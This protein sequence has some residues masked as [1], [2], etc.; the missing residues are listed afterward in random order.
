M[1]NRGKPRLFIQYFYI[2]I[3]LCHVLYILIHQ[4]EN[5][6]TSTEESSEEEDEEEDGDA[7][8]RTHFR[9]IVHFYEPGL[10]TYVPLMSVC[11][12]YIQPGGIWVILVVKKR[13][14]RRR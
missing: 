3:V 12:I 6:G 4:T 11:S 8:E 14:L 5:T 7:G 10:L 9:G 1:Y 13:L 2:R